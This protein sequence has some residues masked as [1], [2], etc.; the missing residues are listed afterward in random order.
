MASCSAQS[1]HSWLSLVAGVKIGGPTKGSISSCSPTIASD[2]VSRPETYEVV[3]LFGRAHGRRLQRDECE[4]P[5]LCTHWNGDATCGRL[6]RH[7]RLV[8]VNHPTILEREAPLQPQVFSWIGL[9]PQ[10]LC[11]CEGKGEHVQV[12]LHRVHWLI[13]SKFG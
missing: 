3:S 9:K 4:Q 2:C 12:E 10:S 6:G 5:T 1:H 13:G 7:K 8:V 11:V